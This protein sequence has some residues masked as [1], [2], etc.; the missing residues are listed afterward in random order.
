[1]VGDS[2]ERVK[3]FYVNEHDF[4]AHIDN[5]SVVLIENHKISVDFTSPNG[6]ARLYMYGLETIPFRGVEVDE[7]GDAYLFPNEGKVDLFNENYYP[8]IP[9]T[10]QIRVVVG[11]Q[12]WFAPFTIRP[13]ELTT[14]QL[15]LMREQLEEKLRG[16]ALDFISRQFSKG[17]ALGKSLPPKM[18]K[19]FL[20]IT[21]HF[22]NVMA[23]LSDLYTKVNFHTR[24]EYRIVRSDRANIVDEITIRNR[25]MHP[26]QKG[27]LKVPVR[28]IQYD[29]PE[30]IWIKQIMK[31]LI[32]IL[33]EFEVSVEGYVAELLAEIDELRQYEFQPST[34]LVLRHKA[35]VR[36][37]L[38][39]YI[40]LV[41]Q[42]K[43]GFQLI[44]SAHW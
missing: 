7:T 2:E 31:R 23:A 28:T 21:K 33:N 10:Y 27:L 34:K 20:T 29:L 36:E 1:M 19:H 24:N 4:Y 40:Q 5:P 16:L 44:K 13:K 3:W 26:E 41:S 11:D 32:T 30:N 43:I 15:D 6:S 39:S 14:G 37:E 38:D 9:G 22:P 25:L 18:L 42:M 8:L 35:K 12:V 17:Q